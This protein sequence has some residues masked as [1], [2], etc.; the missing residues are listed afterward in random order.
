MKKQLL[1]LVCLLAACG[2][3]GWLLTA[4]GNDAATVNAN[5]KDGLLL[6]ETLNVSFQSVGGRVREVPAREGDA[7]AEGDI[8]VILD[9]A[10]LKL[11]QDQLRAQQAAL[12][13]QIAAARAQIGDYEQAIQQYAVET[14][15]LNLGNIQ[16][17]YDQTAALFEAGAVSG[18]NLD[19]AALRL[20]QAEIVLG[21]SRETLGRAQS[22][23]NA[24]IL[25]VTALEEQKS[26]LAVQQASLELQISRLELKA[27]AAGTVMS[28]IPKPGENVSPNAPMIALQRGSLYFDIYVPETSVRRFQEAQSTPVYVAAL[29]KTLSGEIRFV[30]SAPQYAS[31]RAARDGAETDISS[32]Q[33][34][35]V[36]EEEGLLPGMTAE[37]RLDEPT[38]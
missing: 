13:A 3:G 35:I 10:D 36:L 17:I 21:Q 15:E 24:A 33:V 18:A 12:E 22:A 34:R 37:V 25:G 27:P 26:A 4:R 19:D 23:H 16:K 29:D 9:D 6:A 1:L 11:Q 32:F 5:I 38:V 14:A 20:R 31:V 8:L 28:V 30:L 2:A 7:V